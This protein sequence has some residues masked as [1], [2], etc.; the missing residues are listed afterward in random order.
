MTKQRYEAL[1]DFFL[2]H[3]GLARFLSGLDRTFAGLC[4]CLY[5]LLLALLLLR[6]D[7]RFWRCLLVPAVS[8]LLLSVL[9]RA[10]N[11][12]RPYEVYGIPP[13][14]SKSTAGCSFP[15]R[16]IFSL[17]VIACAFLW[18]LPS[19]GGLLL[20]LGVGMAVIRVLL[21]VHFPRDVLAGAACG[22]LAGLIGFVLIP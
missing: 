3:V 13:T 15:S 4:Y 9:R 5:P 14:L 11:F 16:H 20:G 2:R 7:G 21:G 8:F 19:V 6:Q 10:L 18:V 12:P 22:L 17:C 1:H